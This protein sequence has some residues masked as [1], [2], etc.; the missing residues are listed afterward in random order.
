MLYVGGDLSRKRIDWQAVWPE[1]S[2]CAAGAAPPD[3]DGLAGLASRLLALDREVVVVIES[4]TGARF[5]H[6]ELERYGLEVRIADAR[7]AK[8]AAELLGRVGAKTD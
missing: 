3:R 4:M 1:G 7:K 5:V 8:M 6:D 2:E